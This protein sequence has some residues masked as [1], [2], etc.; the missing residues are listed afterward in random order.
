MKY[1][2]QVAQKLKQ[3]FPLSG[4]YL[5]YGNAWGWVATGAWEGEEV[6]CIILNIIYAFKTL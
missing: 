4:G 1:G 6:V 5:G 2:V 3:S